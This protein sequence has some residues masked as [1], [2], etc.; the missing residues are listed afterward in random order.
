MLWTPILVKSREMKSYFWNNNTSYYV[1]VMM[2]IVHPLNRVEIRPFLVPH[3]QPRHSAEVAK[4]PINI[5]IKR[6]V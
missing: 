2:M 6:L 5:Q 4:H 3:Q 1:V